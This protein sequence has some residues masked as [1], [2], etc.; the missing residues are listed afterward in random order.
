MHD[1]KYKS[2]IQTDGHV[3]SPFLKPLTLL[4]QTHKTPAKALK[5]DGLGLLGAEVDWTMSMQ[6]RTMQSESARLI[7][8]VCFASINGVEFSIKNL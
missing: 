6:A 2:C 4:I 5:G 3:H 7:L 1:R 8:V